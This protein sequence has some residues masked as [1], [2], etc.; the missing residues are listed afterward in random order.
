MIFLHSIWCTDWLTMKGNIEWKSTLTN[1]KLEDYP[2]EM[3][4]SGK[5]K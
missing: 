1:H 2:G 3:D 5:S 4:I